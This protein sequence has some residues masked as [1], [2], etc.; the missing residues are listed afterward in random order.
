VLAE[1][2]TAP[3]QLMQPQCISLSFW[4]KSTHAMLRI[5]SCQAANNSDHLSELLLT[6]FSNDREGSSLL[7][8]VK[9]HAETHLGK[10]ELC[11]G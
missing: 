6:A 8:S 1:I 7:E 3:T 10:D 9:H 5:L 11:F 2:H 4:M